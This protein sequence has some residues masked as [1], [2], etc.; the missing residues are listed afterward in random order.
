MV[1][2]LASSPSS[3]ST[4]T[5]SAGSKPISGA[6][7]PSLRVGSPDRDPG[8]AFGETRALGAASHR[9]IKRGRNEREREQTRTTNSGAHELWNRDTFRRLN[10]KSS[11]DSIISGSAPRKHG[12]HQPRLSVLLPAAGPGALLPAAVPRPHRAHCRVELRVLRVGQSGLGRDHVLRLERRLR[13]R[14]RPAEAV[15]PARR[16]GRPAA[17]D[18]SRGAAHAR[19]EG[20]AGRSRSSPT[21]ACSRSSS[22]PASSA[23]T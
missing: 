12:L 7:A 21:S 11:A 22:T 16:A 2:Q 4:R 17:G 23:R 13:L 20:A 10:A 9:R 1:C 19:D 15:R 6:A 5:S 8:Q 3:S 18:R 14:H